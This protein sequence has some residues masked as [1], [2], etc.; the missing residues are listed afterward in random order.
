TGLVSHADSESK[1]WHE[2]FGHLNYR[3]LKELSTNGMVDGIPRVLCLEGVFSG[4]GL[5]KKHQDPFPKNF[6][7]RV[8]SSLELVH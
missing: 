6:S 3:Y 1:L 4:Y 2:R 5:G 8:S 7:K